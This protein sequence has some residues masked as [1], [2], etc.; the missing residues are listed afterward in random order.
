MRP[1][2]L[3]ILAALK[4][5][6]VPNP[7]ALAARTTTLLRLSPTANPLRT[8]SVQKQS[9]LRFLSSRSTGFR[10][11]NGSS[12]DNNQRQRKQKEWDRKLSNLESEKLYRLSS[13]NGELSAFASWLEKGKLNLFPEYQRDYV[14]KEDKAS[15]L[16]VAVP[17]SVTATCHQLPFMSGGRVRAMSLMASK[18]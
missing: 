9:T 10:S 14:W 4:V 1:S 18:D 7:C 6:K 2:N 5:G 3:A 15:R 17:S 12:N 13:N 11:S 16:I 8:T